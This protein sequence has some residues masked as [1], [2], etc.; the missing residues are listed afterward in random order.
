MSTALRDRRARAAATHRARRRAGA[1]AAA[2][3]VPALAMGASAPAAAE[4]GAAPGGAHTGIRACESSDYK[5]I[6]EG[7]EAAAGTM[8][9]RFAMSRIMGDGPGE[10]P[11][12]QYTPVAMHWIDSF[13]GERVGD[14]AR[15]DDDP[16]E[17]FVVEPGGAASL[18]VRQPNPLNYPEEDC[19]P[20]PVAG[21]QVYLRFED[22]EGVY[23][24]TGGQDVM[25]SLPGK[26]VP[27]V[28]VGP[29]EA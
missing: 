25:C 13:E 7:R 4:A 15:Y 12:V 16:P 10:E 22:D 14:W 23:G 24:P 21:I 20:Q 29:Y 18:T 9:I 6:Y 26:G 28:F 5:L 27:T 8:Y 11:C 19:E 3:A 2:V 17:P 1:L